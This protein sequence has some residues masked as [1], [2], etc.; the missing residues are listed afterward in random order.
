M[1]INDFIANVRSAETIEKMKFVINTEMAYVRAKLKESGAAKDPYLIAE[2]VFLDTIGENVGWGQM[3]AVQLMAHK[4]LSVKRM[5]YLATGQL[6]DGSSELSVLVTQTLIGDIQSGD[7]YF[8]TLALSFIA[9]YGNKEIC[10]ETAMLVQKL[11]ERSSNTKLLKRAAMA[12]YTSMIQLPELIQS[13]KN[14]FQ[15]LLNANDNGCIMAGTNCIIKGLELFPRMQELWKIF[16]APYTQILR[17]LVRTRPPS[18]YAFG[19]TFDPFLQCKIIKVLSL[20][21]CES[22]EF[23]S[24]LQE[25]ITTTDARKN[26]QR[27][28][29][30]QAVEAVVKIQQNQSLRGLSFN[31][32]GRLLSYKDPNILYSALSLFDRV[33]YQ[34]NHIINHGSSDA[35]ALQRYKKHIVRC[36]DNPDAHLRRVALSVILAL[37]DE[38][39]VESFV[40]EMLQYIRLANS[41]F[42]SELINR[43]YYAILKFSKDPNFVRKSVADIVFDNGDYVSTEL[44]T[45]FVDYTMKHPQIHKDLLLQLPPLFMK[46][47]NQAAIQLGSFLYG[48]LANSYDESVMENMIQLLSMPQVKDQSRMMLISSLSKICARFR[49]YEKVVPVMQN[50]TNSNNIEIQ[51]RAG[52]MVTLLTMPELAEVILAPSALDDKQPTTS[53]VKMETANESKENNPDNL[54]NLLL[55]VSPAPQQQP[56]PQKQNDALSELL[57]APPIQQNVVK[58]PQ[59]IP[60]GPLP[61][62]PNSFPV[63]K[64][65]DFAVYG[66]TQVNQQN[67]NQIALMLTTVPLTD[68]PL[69]NFVM[70]FRASPGWKLLAKDPSEKMLRPMKERK[71]VTQ[72]VYLMSSGTPFTLNIAVSFM[73][74]AQPI[75]EVGVLQKLN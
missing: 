30:Y 11:I 22:E 41:D 53:P 14:S 12:L 26:A 70:E 58:A 62:P 9:N 29:L 39:N 37:I 72:I 20:L 42:R 65:V 6:L 4:T 44:I 48:E 13:F 56:Q 54:L 51:Q 23:Q 75:R 32:T 27:A 15:K 2:L 40:P 49:Q 18:Q 59:V 74:G 33:L 35:V 3:Y 47:D 57:S 73:I 34:D 52:E 25:I 46:P 5:G 38:T 19:V 61:P 67:P 36:I 21:N 16:I 10:T 55:D 28:I 71:P 66:Q 24:I 50:L 68:K 8:Q 7:F 45:A 69:V 31:Q 43:L 63:M 64:T 60:D 1:G 17:A